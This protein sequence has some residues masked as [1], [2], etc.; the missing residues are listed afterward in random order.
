M[1]LSSCIGKTKG[2]YTLSFLLVFFCRQ[3]VVPDYAN[4]YLFNLMLYVI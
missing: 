4:I 2:A 1:K 3:V